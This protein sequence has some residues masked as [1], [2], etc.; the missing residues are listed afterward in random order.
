ML[1]ALVAFVRPALED[2]GDLDLV[3]DLCEQL[4]AR[5]GGATR[6]RR[7]FEKTE[8]LAEV[9]RDLVARTEESGNDRPTWLVG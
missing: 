1:E 5:G 6:Q 8:D 3:E 4:L 9:V 2:A 7:V